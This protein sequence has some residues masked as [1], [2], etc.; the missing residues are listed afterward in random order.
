MEGLERKSF[1][2]DH[3]DILTIPTE[4]TTIFSL[5][6]LQ[7]I[8]PAAFNKYMLQFFSAQI[9]KP[10]DEFTAWIAKK[11]ALN[12]FFAKFSTIAKALFV[13]ILEPLLRLIDELPSN[14]LRRMCAIPLLNLPPPPPPLVHD[15]RCER[16]GRDAKLQ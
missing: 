4:I 1:R 3:G 7:N 5:K 11:V 16:E 6:K 8:S 12:A 14:V 10:A 2:F 15:L 13:Y 9:I